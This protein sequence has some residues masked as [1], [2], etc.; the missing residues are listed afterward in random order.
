MDLPPLTHAGAYE[1]HGR[2]QFAACV[3]PDIERRKAFAQHWGIATEAGSIEE[4][5]ITPGAIDV[6][7]ICSPTFL[8]PQHVEQ[9]LALRPRTIFC[10]K[11]VSIDV[12]DAKDLFQNVSPEEY[13]IVNYSRCVIQTYLLLLLIRSSHWGRFG[14]LWATTTRE[15]STTVVTWSSCCY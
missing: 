2:F 12:A 7:S 3:D 6:V 1:R 4:L 15:F 11:P 9:A 10:V 8:H 5:G 13:L 14:R